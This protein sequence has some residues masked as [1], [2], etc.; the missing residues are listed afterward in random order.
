ME[1]Y[2]CPLYVQSAGRG[3][4]SLIYEFVLRR[5]RP[6]SVFS[7]TAV[8]IFDGA[9]QIGTASGDSPPTHA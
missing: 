7:S 8:L 5:A 6:K 4:K 9:T 1:E 2:N 3:F